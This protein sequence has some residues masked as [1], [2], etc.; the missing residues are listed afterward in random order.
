MI[1]QHRHYK[2]WLSSAPPLL[3]PYTPPPPPGC[4]YFLRNSISSFIYL[5]VINLNDPATE[6]GLHERPGMTEGSLGP[7]AEGTAG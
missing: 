5:F 4:F 1:G 6:A 3:F 7:I 2:V